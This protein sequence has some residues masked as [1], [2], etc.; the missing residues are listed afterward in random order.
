MKKGKIYRSVSG[1]V[2]RCTV[3]SIKWS[4]NF[5]GTIIFADS[6]PDSMHIGTYRND[7]IVDRFTEVKGEDKEITLAAADIKGLGI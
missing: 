4:T 7:W 1:I 6:L 5:C 2:V 3:D